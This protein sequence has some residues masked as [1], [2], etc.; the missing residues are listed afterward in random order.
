MSKH[1]TPTPP[2]SRQTV[3]DGYQPV[4]RGYQPA[5]IA[6]PVKPQGGHQPTTGQGPIAP[7]PNQGTGGKK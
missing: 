1:P 2:S 4:G 6:T 5:A 7:P 3:G